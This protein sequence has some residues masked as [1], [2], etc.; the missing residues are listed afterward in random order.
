MRGRAWLDKAGSGIGRTAIMAGL[1]AGLLAGGVAMVAAATTLDL[2]P[3]VGDILVFRHGAR[4][5]ADWEFAVSRSAPDAATCS[6]RPEV[7]AAHGGSLVVEERFTN[8]RSFRVHWAGGPTS[9]GAADCGASA[10]LRVSGTD[11]QLL[12]N[13]VGGPGVE[14]TSFT[15]F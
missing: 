10:D 11:L 4:V 5:P 6:L 14:P 3:K 13:V 12:S 8:P 1:I 15:R 7:M 2:G 9:V